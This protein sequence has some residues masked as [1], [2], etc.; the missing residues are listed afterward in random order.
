[1]AMLLVLSVM[2]KCCWL[3]MVVGFI[4]FS[5]AALLYSLEPPQ[6]KHAPPI[7]SCTLTTLTGIVAILLEVMLIVT[8]TTCHAWRKCHSENRCG[9]YYRRLEKNNISSARELAHKPWAKNWALVP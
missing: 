5:S 7:I 2:H 4:L 6:S 1:M 9:I 8:A 3:L